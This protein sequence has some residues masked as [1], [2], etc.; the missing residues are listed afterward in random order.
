MPRI[1]STTLAF[2]ALAGAGVL[3]GACAESRLRVQRDFGE[4]VR[5]DVASQI[6]DPDA[7]YAGRPGPGANGIRVDAAQERYL[8][9]KVVEPATTITQTAVSGGGGGGQAGSTPPSAGQ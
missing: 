7:H 9:G 8:Q 5:Q 4:A 6:A 3:L 1:G 2:A